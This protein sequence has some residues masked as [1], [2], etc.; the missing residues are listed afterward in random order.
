MFFLFNFFVSSLIQL[1]ICAKSH[2][3]CRHCKF[4]KRSLTGYEFSKCTRFIS[5][6]KKPHVI[7]YEYA[8][9]VRIDET[10]CGPEGKNYENKGYR[11]MLDI[12]CDN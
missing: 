8:D 10:R 12:I 1:G 7:V 6:I 11:D 4:F 9:L 3:N 5:E 2:P